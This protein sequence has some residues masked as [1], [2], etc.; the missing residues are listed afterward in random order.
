M[1]NSFFLY[2]F[3]HIFLFL[4]SFS[5]HSNIS[6]FLKI[7]LLMWTKLCISFFYSL[8]CVNSLCFLRFS[9][10]I[11]KF[12]KVINSL[13][14]L[15]ILMKFSMFLAYLFFSSNTFMNS[16]LFLNMSSINCSRKDSLI[17][18][19]FFKTCFYLLSNSFLTAFCFFY[20][21]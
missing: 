19:I 20:S 3:K 11:A 8:K 17:S 16:L 14:F 6:S 5:T 1:L 13:T 2:S 9:N 21:F 10:W 18:N 12:S 7:I 4:V 15:M